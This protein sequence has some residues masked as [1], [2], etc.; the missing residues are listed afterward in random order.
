MYIYMYIYIHIYVYIDIYTHMYVYIY[1]LPLRIKCH[2]QSRTRFFSYI[3]KYIDISCVRKPG[4]ITQNHVNDSNTM[5]HELLY[6]H[7]MRDFE[8]SVQISHTRDMYTFLYI[9]VYIYIHIYIY[10]YIYVVPLKTK[11]RHTK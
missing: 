6:S 5:N 3:C 2:I 8:W 1:I 9:Y 10:I 4:Q 11:C 7:H